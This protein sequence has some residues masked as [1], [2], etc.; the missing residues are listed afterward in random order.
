MWRNDFCARHLFRW[1]IERNRA[2][3]D[4]PN[5]PRGGAVRNS[6]RSSS[7]TVS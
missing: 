3:G 7:T 1:G 2:S 5:F 4:H 6:G